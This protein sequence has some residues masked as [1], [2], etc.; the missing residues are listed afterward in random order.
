MSVVWCELGWSQVRYAT[1]VAVAVCC[2]VSPQSTAVHT[3]T[4]LASP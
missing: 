3:V 2:V 1:M 4:L